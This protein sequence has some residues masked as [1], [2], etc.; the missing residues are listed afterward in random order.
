MEPT[1]LP[2]VITPRR[3]RLLPQLINEAAVTHEPPFVDI[4]GEH[5]HRPQQLR[6]VRT[7]HV[8]PPVYESKGPLARGH[9]RKAKK[10]D[11]RQQDKQGGGTPRQKANTP[12]TPGETNLCTL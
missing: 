4:L 9:R 8:G 6:L 10:T 3:L 12:T 5:P 2:L 1:T 11:Q 7:E